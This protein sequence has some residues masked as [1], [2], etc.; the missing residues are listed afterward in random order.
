[1]V[2]FDRN[3][4]NTFCF[5]RLSCA[6][7]VYKLFGLLWCDRSKEMSTPQSCVHYC[8]VWPATTI[9][10]RYICSFIRYL[11]DMCTLFLLNVF[12]LVS[13]VEV[14]FRREYSDFPE[15]D[16]RKNTSYTRLDMYIIT[17]FSFIRINI[18]FK[19]EH[20]FYT[21]SFKSYKIS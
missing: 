14:N 2:Y 21:W 5:Q 8:T 3:R 7:K 11:P 9:P 1:M 16:V 10:V 17:T 15:R 19:D 20:S 4:S 13:R 12:C 6:K 18:R